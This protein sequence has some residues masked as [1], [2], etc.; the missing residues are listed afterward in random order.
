M[1]AILSSELATFGGLLDRQAD[2][3]TCEVE[4]DDLDPELFA[5]RDDLL[6]AVDV[7]RRHLRDVDE[8]FDAVADLNER[9]ELH[10]LG[11]STVDEL[12][13]LVAFGEFL[14]RILLRCLQ[15]EADAL[16]AEVDVEH[17]DLDRIANGDDGTGVVDMLPGELGHV[18]ESVHAAEV[19]KCA[20][21]HD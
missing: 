20:E 8:A 10:E 3:T 9:T 1:L 13:D 18:N 19:D 6:G 21:R 15:R 14:P 12:T 17:L 5:W 16:A 4:I 11:D 7:V 2:A